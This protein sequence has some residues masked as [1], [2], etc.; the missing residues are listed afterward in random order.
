MK[1]IAL[2]LL[3]AFVFHFS[4]A[5]MFVFD[6]TPPLTRAPQDRKAILTWDRDELVNRANDRMNCELTS[7]R[8]YD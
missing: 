2:L 5:R 4:Q 1:S 6:K 8:G 7:P 3:G